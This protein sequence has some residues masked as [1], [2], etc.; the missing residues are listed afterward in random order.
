MGSGIFKESGLN[1]VPNP[2]PEKDFIDGL[3]KSNDVMIFSKSQCS[4]CVKAKSRLDQLNVKY[5]SLEID[6]H[7]NCPGE[8]CTRVIQS[9]ILQ[10][11]MKT[12]PQI[13]YKGNLVGGYTELEKMI[14]NGAFKNGV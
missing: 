2:D 4:Y 11:R 3:I 14:A 5:H 10:T 9:L 7:K 8:D 1:Q 6:Q 13:F 12:V